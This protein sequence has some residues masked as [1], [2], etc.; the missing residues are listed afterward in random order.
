M[1][2]HFN[3]YLKKWFDFLDRN[4][5]GKLDAV[6][7]IGAPKATTM[8][9]IMRNGA[10]FQGEPNTFLTLAALRKSPGESATLDDFVDYYRRNNLQA[11]RIPPTLRGR[12]YQDQPGEVLFK[13]LDFNNDGKLSRE[14]VNA[15]P[16][17]SQ[18]R[19]QR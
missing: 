14:E 9:Q 4:G 6:E 13:I 5:D 12:Q 8:A 10:F 3:G 16:A 17:P 19:P 1:Q 11:L 7:L 15:A 2:A 18:V